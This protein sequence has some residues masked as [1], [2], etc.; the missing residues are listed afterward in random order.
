VRRHELFEQRPRAAAIAGADRG[1]E[2]AAPQPAAAVS[3]IPGK[4]SE[5]REAHRAPV[6]A[7]A[8]AIHA[9]AAHDGDAPLPIGP[10]TEDR[11][12]VVTDDCLA[13]PSLALELGRD[14]AVVD[15]N[16][17]PGE[18]EHAERGDRR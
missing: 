14:P 18:A 2:G 5:R 8:R 3:A 15:R 17:G 12:R 1:T 9:G 4:L 10:S 6:R 16:V 11:E 13:R 7:D